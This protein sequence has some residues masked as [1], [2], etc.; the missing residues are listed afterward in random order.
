MADVIPAVMAALMNAALSPFLFGNPKLRFDAPHV[1]FTRSSL[2]SRRTSSSTWRPASL[3]APIGITSGST[4][5][6][7]TGM[8]WSCARSTVR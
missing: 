1:V 3:I 6:S 5:T 8:P 2:R 4:T 7:L